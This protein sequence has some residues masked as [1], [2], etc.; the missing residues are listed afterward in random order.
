[1]RCN[2]FRRGALA[3]ENI[4]A[5]HDS[6]KPAGD[7]W[8]SA[9]VQ[10]YAGVVVGSEEKRIVGGPKSCRKHVGDSGLAASIASVA[11]SH[12]HASAHFSG[13][14]GGNV[15]G[16]LDFGHGR[17]LEQGWDVDVGIRWRAAEVVMMR[18][19]RDVRRS[20]DQIP[21]ISDLRKPGYVGV[22]VRHAEG[23]AR[24]SRRDGAGGGEPP[25]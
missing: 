16:A 7:N 21:C 10:V 6:A 9:A 17:G 2:L 15:R 23:C 20:F 12:A 8:R 24:H 4:V 11:F 5:E 18:E 1:M 19:S 3:F 22:N 14:R 25:T 13:G